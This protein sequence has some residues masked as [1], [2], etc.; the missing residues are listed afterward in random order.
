MSITDV[1][2]GWKRCMQRPLV[3]GGGGHCDPDRQPTVLSNSV[4]LCRF[5]YEGV[6][7]TFSI[8]DCLSMPIVA[9]YSCVGRVRCFAS[10]LQ[11][12]RLRSANCQYAVEFSRTS[13]MG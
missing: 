13:S 10:S 1:D 5:E 2:Y 11:P 6:S 12:Q 8:L 7:I 4:E 9:G 3:C